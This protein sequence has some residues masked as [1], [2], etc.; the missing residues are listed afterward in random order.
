[1]YDSANT[2]QPLV[3]PCCGAYAYI[4]WVFSVW[5]PATLTDAGFTPGGMAAEGRVRKWGEACYY[6][7]F[8]AATGCCNCYRQTHR[9]H[10]CLGTNVVNIKVRGDTIEPTPVQLYLAPGESDQSATTGHI[11][12]DNLRTTMHGLP[13]DLPIMFCE[14]V[15]ALVL[16]QVRL[17]RCANDLSQQQF[18]AGANLVIWPGERHV[19][20]DWECQYSLVLCYRH[21]DI[22]HTT[23][24]FLPCNS[25]LWVSAHMWYWNSQSSLAGTLDAQ[26]YKQHT[27]RSLASADISWL[28]L[29]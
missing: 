12:I 8:G 17:Q 11:L 2:C 27:A 18:I 6:G 3:D 20:Y 14:N 10:G 13:A 5:Q 28:C 7:L 24:V 9:N 1:M 23:W 21:F 29:Q 26:C 19:S 4:D 25:W 15:H 16:Q 22:D